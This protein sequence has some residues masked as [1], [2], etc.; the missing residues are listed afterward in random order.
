[1]SVSRLINMINMNLTADNTNIVGIQ[2][3]LFDYC[4]G[5]E[6]FDRVLNEKITGQIDSNLE[7]NIV[8]T[9]VNHFEFDTR[10][11]PNCGKL[12]L[13]KKKFVERKTIIDK[14][15]DVVLYLKEY[16]CKSCKCYPKVEL[17][18]VLEKYKR[19]SIVFKEKLSKKAR[20][21]TK[22]LRKTSKDLKVDDVT[23]SHQSIAN[24]LNVKSEGELVFD[25]E[26]ISGYI[27]YDE[28]HLDIDGEHYP[29]AQ[30]LDI[31]SN[32]TIAIKI[33]D[34]VTSEN[35][36][37]FIKD[38][39][40]EDKRICLL[41]DHDTTYISVVENL[42][43]DKQQL[44]LFHFWKLLKRK[45]NEII[46]KNNSTD[47]EIKELK[48]YAG[49]IISIFLSNDKE[50][51]IYRLN[52]FFKK[53]KSVPEDLKNYYNKKIVRDMHKL[54]H[55]LFNPIIPKTNNILESK[56]SSAQQKSDKKRFKTISGCLSY[57]KP[58]TERQN[59][60]LKRC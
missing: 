32:Q 48:K 34:S 55:H 40:P 4:D 54:T 18:N 3:N 5:A 43:F 56:F 42:E 29:K 50:E 27:A 12:S 46:K 58:I 28:Q 30:L 37:N 31:V 49:R 23:L 19:P 26:T 38:H 15:G 13:I 8:L 33:L 22:S 57:L 24:L 10:R 39:I 51:F 16:F 6:D 2:L 17:P 25:V 59:D 1:M 11:C 36:E 53:W 14:I 44:C 21:G 20:T 45:V 52:R 9:D 47:D 7:N 35:V 41:T 60:E